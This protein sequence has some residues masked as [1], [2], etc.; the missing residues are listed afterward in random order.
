MS[1]R[2]VVRLSAPDGTVAGQL[3][4][5]GG[6]LFSSSISGRGP[7]TGAIDREPA[8][9]VETAFSNLRTLLGRAGARSDELG[10]VTVCLADARHARLVEG[11][12]NT[13]FADERNRPV[14]RI[15]LYPL[16]DG[17]LIQLQ[18]I[19]VGGRKRRPV[20]FPG[21]SDG[22][23][24]AVGVR[25]GDVA[26]SAPID[27]RDPSSGRRSDDRKSQMRQ[28]FRNMEAF[29]REAGGSKEDLIHVLI[30]IRGRD[31]QKDMLDVWLEEFP[32]DGERPAR[33]AIFDETLEGESRIIELLCVA[34]LG[35]GRRL[36]LEVPGIRKRHPNPMGCKVGNLVFSSGIGGD[37]PSGRAA[38]N[39]ADVRAMFC[40]EN[41]RTLMEAAGGSLADVGLIAITVNDYAD[42]VAILRQWRRFFPDPADEPARHVMAYGGRGSY[43][44][45]FHVVAALGDE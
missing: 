1:H 41:T 32:V 16:P 44:V 11:P 3:V 26:F 10:L 7:R 28:A 34:V 29:V 12:W 40:L 39:S 22:P 4:Q 21:V 23:S 42:E 18:V 30:F 15:N 17:E 35:R 45:Q 36:D 13:L 43:S 14:R 33:K 9:Q 31:D 6:M 20:E 38:S 37:D 27:G 5:V 19:G 25:M 2:E 24:Q 8:G